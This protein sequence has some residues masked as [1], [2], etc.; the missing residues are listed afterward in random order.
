M[1]GATYGTVEDI[2][3]LWTVIALAGLVYSVINFGE[4]HK[5]LQVIKARSIHNGRRI[6][7]RAAL[8]SEGFRAIIQAIF[9]LTGVTVLFLPSPP[10]SYHQPTAQVVAGILI[11]WGFIVSSVLLTAKAY[12]ARRVRQLLTADLNG[13]GT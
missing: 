7:A 6:I 2:E 1:L 4:A 8:W 3:V 5:D 10:T 11:R 12:L 9:F 13:K